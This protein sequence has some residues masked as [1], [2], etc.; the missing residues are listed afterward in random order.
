MKICAFDVIEGGSYCKNWKS[1]NPEISECSCRENKDLLTEHLNGC[2]EGLVMIHTQCAAATNCALGIDGLLCM[3]VSGD[4][5]PID[6]PSPKIHYSK[7][8]IP[9]SANLSFLAPHFARLCKNLEEAGGDNGKILSAWAEWERPVLDQV[10]GILSP[11]ALVPL[12]QKVMGQVKRKLDELI[13]T[14]GLDGAQ[15]LNGELEKILDISGVSVL[16]GQIQNTDN[17]FLLNWLKNH[18]NC[19]QDM[20]RRLL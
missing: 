16:K 11:M 5:L 13:K 12:D 2:K 17:D 7:R 20:S 8:K 15:L 9:S 10:I 3:F 18:S 1:L 19:L 6:D 14:I 4:E